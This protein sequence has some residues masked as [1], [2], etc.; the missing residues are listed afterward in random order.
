MD[1]YPTREY[2]T[3]RSE[4]YSYETLPPS[5]GRDYAETPPEF[6]EQSTD[7]P[8]GMGGMDYLMD[9]PVTPSPQRVVPRR[10]YARPAIFEPS[11]RRQLFT[12]EEEEPEFGD[13]YDQEVQDM[14]R[15]REQILRI[16]DDYHV[17]LGALGEKMREG[18]WSNADQSQVSM[19]YKNILVEYTTKLKYL[20]KPVVESASLLI[21]KS[22]AMIRQG[23]K[24]LDTT[25][26]TPMITMQRTTPEKMQRRREKLRDKN[27]PV[28]TVTLGRF[29]PIG[30]HYSQHSSGKMSALGESIHNSEAYTELRRARSLARKRKYEAMDDALRRASIELRRLPDDVAI[31][32]LLYHAVLS[33]NNP[34]LCKSTRARAPPKYRSIMGD[35]WFQGAVSDIT[36]E[37][38]T[39]GVGV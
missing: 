4:L 25:R 2:V 38:R 39:M 34:T 12:E 13:Y 37:S 1:P 11:T 16:L 29:N 9:M 6:M 5:P 33:Q 27:V 21:A 18:L 36:R 19:L 3:P 22:L 31:G 35:S 7:D 10:K 8:Y 30:N 14:A 28:S 24:I 20:S 15:N 26:V 23:S 32:A 17:Q